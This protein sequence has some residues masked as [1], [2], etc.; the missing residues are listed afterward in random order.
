MWQMARHEGHFFLDRFKLFTR[1]QRQK[2]CP[3]EMVIGSH[4]RHRHNAHSRSDEG[5]SSLF[6]AIPT[7][8]EVEPFSAIFDRIPF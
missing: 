3:H 2:L 8:D 4:I 5:E 7:V 1:Q 6:S